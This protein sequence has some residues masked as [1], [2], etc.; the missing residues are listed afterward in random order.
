MLYGF[1]YVKELR[2]EKLK[3]KDGDEEEEA[4]RMEQ[5]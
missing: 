3:M 1:D 2:K 4:K 5:Y